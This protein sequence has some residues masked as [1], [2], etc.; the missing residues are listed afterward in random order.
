MQAKLEG[1][2]ENELLLQL[3]TCTHLVQLKFKS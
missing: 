3:H 1:V 2:E